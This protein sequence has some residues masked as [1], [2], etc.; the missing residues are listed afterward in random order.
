MINFLY[1]GTSIVYKPGV[2]IGG[3]VA[4]DCGTSRA[5][6]YFLEPLIALGPFAK[7][8]MNVTLNG[9]T[10]DNVDISVSAQ[11]R[12]TWRQLSTGQVQ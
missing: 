3:K 1:S 7:T 4:H 12:C 9:I 5:I 2:I 8:P 11:S 6:G 10:N